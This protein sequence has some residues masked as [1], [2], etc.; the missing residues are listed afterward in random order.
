MQFKELHEK[1]NKLTDRPMVISSFNKTIT[2]NTLRVK[3]FQIICEILGYDFYIKPKG[4][5]ETLHMAIEEKTVKK[6]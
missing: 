2:N 4:L 1:F 6:L 3:D 5:R